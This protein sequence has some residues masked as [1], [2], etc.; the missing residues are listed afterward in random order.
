MN[1]GIVGDTHNNL[2]SVR[3]MP[4]IFERA[5]VEEII[6]TGDITQAKVLD[7]FSRIDAPLHGVYGNNDLERESLVSAAKRH[8]MQL[9][10]GL[11]ELHWASRR[12]VIGHD[13]L[14]LHGRTEPHHDLALHGHTHLHRRDETIEGTVI[15]DPGEC[16]GML[17]GH[18]RVG[19]VNLASL[20]CELHHF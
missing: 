11:L 17:P 16:A 12:I 3:S 14:E 4:V 18:N 15:F 10:D 2:T 13:P 6:H 5:R 9:V 20:E 1:I 19:V 7:Y 8:G